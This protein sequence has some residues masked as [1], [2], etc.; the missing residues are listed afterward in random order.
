[1]FTRQN[2][3]KKVDK[4]AIQF[5]ENKDYIRENSKGNKYRAKLFIKIPRASRN[6]FCQIR[7]VF[8]L[9]RSNLSGE[10]SA[11]GSK[12]EKKCFGFISSFQNLGEEKN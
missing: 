9:F 5:Q 10:W 2:N 4:H 11:S 8:T 12:N 7:V 6:I 3:T 1:M